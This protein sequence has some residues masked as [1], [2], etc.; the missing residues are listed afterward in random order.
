MQ[1][2]KVLT[3]EQILKAA[4]ECFARFGYIKTNFLDV[5]KRAGIS[6]ALLYTYFKN[7]EDL[8]VTMQA[9]NNES[10]ARRSREIVAS[11]LP[12]KEKLRSVIDIWIIEPYRII[13]K[14]PVPNAWLD[15]LKSVTQSE[16]EFRELFIDS[17]APILGKDAAEIVVLS[18]RGLLDDR[19]PVEVLEKRTDILVDILTPT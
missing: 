4:S 18:Y 6:R 15:Q 19:P 1:D 13:N 2:K 3:R 10:Y 14:S 5:A 11:D 8:F 9:E 17:L 12:E 7:K 16:M